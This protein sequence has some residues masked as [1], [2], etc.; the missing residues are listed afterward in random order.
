M[1]ES[2]SQAIGL[3]NAGM[4]AN[5]YF[6]HFLVQ[7]LD[8]LNAHIAILNRVGKVL[9]VNERWRSFARENSY[10]DASLGLGTNYLQISKLAMDSG[11]REA[12][13]A[14]DGISS[15]IDGQQPRFSS[16]YA[17]HSPW[18]ERWFNL[19]VS[20]FSLDTETY[21]VIAHE[22]VTSRVEADERVRKLNAALCMDLQNHQVAKIHNMHLASQL[23]F[24]QSVLDQFASVCELNLQLQIVSVN[25]IFCEQLGLL[26]SQLLGKSF[27]VLFSAWTGRHDFLNLIALVRQNGCWQGEFRCPSSSNGCRNTS[28][29]IFPK[30]ALAGE[31][32]GYLVVSFDRSN[33]VTKMA[34]QLQSTF[35][36]PILQPHQNGHTTISADDSFPPLTPPMSTNR[37]AQQSELTSQKTFVS[38]DQVPPRTTDTS[39][40]LQNFKILLIEDS[41]DN[42]KLIRHALRRL[43][44]EIEI[45]E[46]GREAIE[47]LT[48]DHSFDGAIHNVPYHI[49][50]TDIQ[51]PILD[52]YS[53][54]KIL[55]KR[56]VRT[57]I[58]AITAYAQPEDQ[59]RCMECGCDA[60]LTKPIDFQE[61]KSLSLELHYRRPQLN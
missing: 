10:Q 35:S 28:I 25:Q 52:G 30:Y 14:F 2:H 16:Q 57:P 33:Q 38:D 34:P 24:Y 60:F 23:E 26:T 44:A 4:S 15:V 19:S 46:N 48:E 54:V 17:C 12:Q 5:D 9:Y 3:L 7:T 20:K 21:I 43:G 59:L 32:V 58:I 45:V 13:D 61:L 47:H 39:K 1:M 36:S 40:P 56:N 49:I 55:R 53:T 22:N 29:K 8:S 51:M 27:E 18:E 41:L 37:P 6:E 42:Q 50:L 11:C 31:F